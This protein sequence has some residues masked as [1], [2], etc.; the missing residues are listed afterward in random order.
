MWNDINYRAQDMW[1]SLRWKGRSVGV[2]LCAGS[3]WD[4]L[5]T[6]DFD[7]SG[8]EEKRGFPFVW[9]LSEGKKIRIRR[10]RIMW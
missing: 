2:W 1:V 7:M 6:V 3:V 8:V 9:E 10:E 5:M 4:F